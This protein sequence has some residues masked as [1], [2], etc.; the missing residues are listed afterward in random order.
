MAASG[1]G[2]LTYQWKKGGA[3]IS[4]ATSASY[5]TPATAA[6]DNG[7]QFSVTVTNSVGSATSNAATLTVTV[8]PVIS[9]QPRARRCSAGQ[10]ATFSVTAIGLGHPDLSVEEEW[11]RDQRR[12]C[13]LVHHPGHPTSDNGAS[14]TVTVTG[15]SG[16]VTSNAATLTVNGRAVDHHAAGEQVGNRRTDR[17]VQRGR[18]RNRH[19]DL[20]MEEGRRGHQ[21]RDF[22]LLYDSGDNV[23]RQRSAIHRDRYQ[24]RTGSVTSTA[25]TLTVNAAATLVL[26]A[27]QSSL[28]FS[29]INIGSNSVL[30]VVFTNAGTGSVTISSVSISGAGFTA[31]GI[32]SGQIIAAGKTATLNVTFTP[33]SAGSLSGT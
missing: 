10:T 8:P 2:T 9:S 30:P 14:F 23:R 11:Q 19:A 27:S 26:N 33:S 12:D 13:V 29:S 4:G 5:T 22:V 24:Q 28:N 7:A 15:T 21:R 31:S 3:A 16:N 25:A 20:S 1:T 32:S 6:S 17:N 18:D